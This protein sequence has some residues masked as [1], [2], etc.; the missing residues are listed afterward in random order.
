MRENFEAAF[1]IIIGLEGHLTND[2][3]DPGGF[4]VYGLSSRFNAGIT[5][6]L[7]LDD[8]KII[9]LNRYWLPAGCDTAPFPFDICL[10][11][12]AVNP[13]RSGNREILDLHP[14]N[15]Q[16]FLILRMNR[17]M[18]YSKDIYVKGHLQRVVRLFNSIKEMGHG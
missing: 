11:D 6:E 18:Q 14:E 13:Q 9:Y 12:G 16:E 1:K 3:N 2:L 4:T 7:T 8:A 5:A 15:W 10:F 17:Y